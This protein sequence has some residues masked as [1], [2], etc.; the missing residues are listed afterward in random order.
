MD[1]VFGPVIPAMPR[2]S[3][4]GWSGLG[5]SVFVWLPEYKIGFSYVMN[6]MNDDAL[7]GPK[8]LRAVIDCVHKMRDS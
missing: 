8:L 6:F 2:G 5:G 3:A 1:F 4:R 7:R